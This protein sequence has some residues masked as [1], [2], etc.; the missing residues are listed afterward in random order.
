[1]I[2]HEVHERTKILHNEC[3]HKSILT[4][5]N[6]LPDCASLLSSS[7]AVSKVKTI[8]NER[9]A[10]NTDIDSGIDTS[11]SCDEKKKTLNNHP[12]LIK[13]EQQHQMRVK[14]REATNALK[15]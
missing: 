12:I 13:S 15:D 7:N 2:S 6:G 4:T 9:K 8:D 3:N 14:R 10:G 11:D 1:M 5:V